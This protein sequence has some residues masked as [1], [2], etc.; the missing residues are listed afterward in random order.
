M[1]LFATPIIF[2]RNPVFYWFR[3]WAGRKDPYDLA[4]VYAVFVLRAKIGQGMADKDANDS[5]SVGS[6][7]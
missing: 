3:P 7:Q 2:I 1:L 5:G 4:A 6:T